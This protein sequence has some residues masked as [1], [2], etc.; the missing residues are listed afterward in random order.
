MVY[1]Q[2]VL[3]PAV[4]KYLKWFPVA[5]I[6]GPRQS[7]KSTMLQHLLRDRYEYLTFD[8]HRTLELFSVDPEKFIRLHGDRVIFDEVQKA[9]Q[10][11]NYIKLAV[12]RDRRKYGRFVLTGSS[13]FA[14]M[15][16]VSETLAGRIGLLSL[17]PFQYSELPNSLREE[18]IFRGSYPELVTRKY[19]GAGDWYASYLDTYLSRDVRSLSNIGDL[20]DFRRCVQ[21]LAARTAQILNMSDLARDIGVTVRTVKKWISVLEASYVLFLL[22]PYYRNLGKRI[23]KSPK[24]YF[25]DT[26]LVSFLVGI[27][28]KREYEKGPMHGP[29]FENYVVSEVLKRELHRT[30]KSEL[31]Y[32]RTNHGVEVDLI[33]DRKSSKDI[34]EVK[35]TE[36]FRPQMLRSIEQVRG[37][38]DAGY[39]IYPGR[40]AKYSDVAKVLNY[41]EFLSK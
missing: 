26:G 7:G 16:G 24:V 11:F 21:L 13:Q 14:V 35:V 2:R 19:H 38:K 37:E 5:G 23:V 34:L 41:H 29:L 40:S 39:L 17:L 15:R 33:V 27:D 6:T 20:H 9:P 22:P 18:S 12:D 3:E 28:S 4:L 1:I 8:D 31:Y 25:F 36:T 32:Y 30:T 10:I